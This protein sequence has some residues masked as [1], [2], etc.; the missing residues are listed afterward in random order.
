METSNITFKWCWW[1]HED[2]LIIWKDSLHFTHPVFSS[3]RKAHLCRS[4]GALNERR[5]P[6][7]LTSHQ[8]PSP[9]SGFLMSSS[10][11]EAGLKEQRAPFLFM[12]FRAGTTSKG[13]SQLLSTA[14]TPLRLRYSKQAEA[15]FYFEQIENSKV[16]THGKELMFNCRQSKRR[17]EKNDRFVKQTNK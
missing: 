9:L 10:D 12:T 7:K 15:K 4:V 8:L 16:Y 6:N 1:K 17:V 13:T 2:C 11:W 5:H 3:K 14:M